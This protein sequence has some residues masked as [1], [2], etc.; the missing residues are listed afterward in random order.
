MADTERDSILWA[1]AVRCRACG[2]AA[3][4]TDAGALGGG[5]IIASFPRPCEHVAGSTVLID[6]RD[7]EMP[8]G[9]RLAAFDELAQYVAGRRCAGR[10]KRG[11]PCRSYAS[12][13]SDYCCAHHTAGKPG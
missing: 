11:R 12:P 2:R 1:G 6:L 7:V 5:W 3:F 4:P 8:A 10:N 13:G 9:A